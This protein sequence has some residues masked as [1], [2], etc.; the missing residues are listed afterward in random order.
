[1]ESPTLPF[2]QGPPS[3]EAHF[4]LVKDCTKPAYHLYQGTVDNAIVYLFFAS[5]RDVHLI[6]SLVP[7]KC[8]ELF[9][10]VSLIPS[11]HRRFYDQLVEQCTSSIASH[12]SWQERCHRNLEDW[13][14]HLFDDWWR[15]L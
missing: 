11:S 9:D 13:L 4:Q 3:E 6:T 5:K 15:P 7:A 14:A 10:I 12:A 1:M 8:P 2:P